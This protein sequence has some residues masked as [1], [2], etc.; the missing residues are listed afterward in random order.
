MNPY[1]ESKK[2]DLASELIKQIGN[3]IDSNSVLIALEMNG[4]TGYTA[5]LKYGE[6]TL[7]DLAEDIYRKCKVLT[8]H[9]TKTMIREKKV[10]LKS[11]QRFI[12]SFLTGLELSIPMIVQ[13]VSIMLLGFSMWA[14][15]GFETRLSTYIAIGTFCSYVVT[16]GFV[17]GI[18]RKGL[19]Y[20]SWENPVLAKKGVYKIYREAM[21]MIFLFGGLLGAVLLIFTWKTTISFTFI[22][23][24]YYLMLAFLWLNLSLLYIR[25]R[26]IATLLTVL[27]P[28]LVIWLLLR[29]K[30]AGIVVSQLIGLAIAN[31]LS[32]FWGYKRFY[33]MSRESEKLLSHAK[34]PPNIWFRESFRRYFLFGIFY[35]AFIMSDRIVN[36]S[37]SFMG[38]SFLFNTA[39]EVGLDFA[40]ICFPLFLILIE[41]ATRE[42]FGRVLLVERNLRSTQIKE[43]NHRFTKYYVVTMLLIPF[44]ALI[45]FLLVKQLFWFL[46]E[47]LSLAIIQ[48]LFSNPTTQFAFDFAYFSYC[49]VGMGLFNSQL[50]FSH[51]R[52]KM[53]LFAAVISFSANVL[54]GSVLS[55]YYSPKFSVIG[56]LLGSGIFFFL[57]T[58]ENFRLMEEFD[59]AS[60]AA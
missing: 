9:K 26:S 52:P 19:Q 11:I 34:L 2:N 4:I 10:V 43:F 58:V 23:L 57:T 16:G 31:L 42:L 20:L 3:P 39:Y 59:Y 15:I 7:D 30:L 50:Q 21:F 24:F 41:Y 6:H 44:V 13:M 18:G 51:S 14:Y 8:L 12:I 33:S 1:I 38:T 28:I 60:Y 32:F 17:Q 54:L 22:T 53:P 49:F 37:F 56:L 5:Q 29:F 46:Y 48:P 55:W 36:W 35:F 40:L 27:I 47:S 25:R 45:F